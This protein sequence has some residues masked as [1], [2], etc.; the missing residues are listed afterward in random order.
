MGETN[1]IFIELNLFLLDNFRKHTEILSVE[2]TALFSL[3]IA[4]ATGWMLRFCLFSTWKIHASHHSR[5]K[6]L[7]SE[8]FL[9]FLE[10]LVECAYTQSCLVFLDPLNGCREGSFA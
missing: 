8:L 6:A 1:L 5:G 10:I 3:T 2:T 7:F 9:Q 4:L